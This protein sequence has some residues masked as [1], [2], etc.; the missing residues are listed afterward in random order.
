[1][2]LEDDLV[3]LGVTGPLPALRFKIWCTAK[4]IDPFLSSPE[5]SPLCAASIVK[6]T[7]KLLP[8]DA[9]LQV[10][11]RFLRTDH[12]ACLDGLVRFVAVPR[13]EEQ[14]R[15]LEAQLS[16]CRCDLSLEVFQLVHD[17]EDHSE[18]LSF[19]GLIS[20]I[21]TILARVVLKGLKIGHVVGPQS[22]APN[23]HSTSKKWP[24]NTAA[25]FPAGPE[26]AV[27]SFASLFRLTKSPI[28]LDFIRIVLPH[29]LSLA[30]SISRSTVFWETM[31]EGLQ[32]SVDKFHEDPLISGQVTSNSTETKE[33]GPHQV[34]RAFTMC[35]TTFITTFTESL[36]HQLTSSSHMS[37]GRKI[38]DLLLKVLLL[39]KT[40]PNQAELATLCFFVAGMAIC[41]ANVLPRHQRPSRIHPVIRM[42][43]HLEKEPDAWAFTQVFAVMG[44]IAAV[45]QCCNASCA[46]T[47]ES[48]TQKLRYCARCR[49]MRYCSSGC[50]KTAWRYHKTVCADLE[51]LNKKV[52]P[53]F[54]D[55][56][57]SSDY[58]PPGQAM[59]EFELEAK[60]LGFTEDRMKEMSAEL[61]PFCH[62]QN[63][64]MWAAPSHEDANH[65]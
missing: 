2:S 4:L 29:C 6:A 57:E 48:S 37:Y 58:G 53:L 27:I 32:S 18:E 51:T 52:M 43:S 62:F 65:Y 34:I 13:T 9:D 16:E 5:R 46:E 50:Q 45:A 60:K 28:I 23:G 25:L 12:H 40:S 44:R 17:S 55:R 26:A 42:Y 14:L 49:L 8:G 30:M 31:V 47:S 56:C 15:L 33:S 38:Y 61:M 39:A 19:K 3:E 11:I 64:G 7:E 36:R 24:A 35:L 20:S 59:V 63:A 41:V 10:C 22:P 54:P 1:M 21:F